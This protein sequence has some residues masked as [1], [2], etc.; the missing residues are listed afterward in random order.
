[1]G[2]IISNKR[3]EQDLLKQ[4]MIEIVALSLR[5]DF[6]KHVKR[7]NKHAEGDEE[8]DNN[9]LNDNDEKV[10]SN[11]SNV[12]TSLIVVP[13]CDQ[14]DY[15]LNN[16]EDFTTFAELLN[17]SIENDLK[18]EGTNKDDAENFT[19]R[20]PYPTF[21]LLLEKDITRALDYYEKIGE[22]PQ[23]IYKKNIKLMNELG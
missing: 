10:D 1:M 21:H 15:D 3:T 7:I 6:Y 16:F 12:C 8:N 2:F 23:D 4:M 19:N 11:I 22:N 18:L 20:S 5:E 17:S 9:D 13:E 14:G